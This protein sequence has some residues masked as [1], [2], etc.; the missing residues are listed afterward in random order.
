MENENGVIA[1]MPNGAVIPSAINKINSRHWCCFDDIETQLNLKSNCGTDQME[2]AWYLA[3]KGIISIQVAKDICYIITS[4]ELDLIPPVQL[5]MLSEIIEK[6]YNDVE[7]F[8]IDLVSED[9]H[10]PIIIDDEYEFGV[11]K[12]NEVFNFSSLQKHKSR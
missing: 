3:R 1:I 5:K 7:N 6:N 9:K 4:P 10:T 12:V 11:D 8:G 2:H